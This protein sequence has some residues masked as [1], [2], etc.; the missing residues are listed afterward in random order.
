VWLGYKK[1]GPSSLFFLYFEFI[2]KTNNINVN[3]WRKINNCKINKLKV[4]RVQNTFEK[5]NSFE[6]MLK[7][8]KTMQIYQKCIFLGFRCF[9]LFFLFF[10]WK[11]IETLGQKLGSNKSI[12][13]LIFTLQWLIK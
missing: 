10:F 6:T 9:F 1:I 11:F 7:M 5:L 2:L 13:Q 3:S 4:E 12:I 8:L